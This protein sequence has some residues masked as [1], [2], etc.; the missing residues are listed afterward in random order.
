MIRVFKIEVLLKTSQYAKS[1][2]RPFRI[3]ID[4]IQNRSKQLSRPYRFV[5]NNIIDE[6]I[7]SDNCAVNN[8]SS[9]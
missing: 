5:S 1:I 6:N 9:V 3:P 4:V 2:H 7:L 8:V